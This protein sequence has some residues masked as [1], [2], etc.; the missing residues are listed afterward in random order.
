[1]F[2]TLLTDFAK[3]DL[4]KLTEVNQKRILKKL[5]DYSENPFLNSKKL[6]NSKIGSYRYRVGDFRIAF[7]IEGN[8]IVVLRIRHRREIYR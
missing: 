7:D 1:M 4:K 6:H 8:D 3:R 5:R 2:R